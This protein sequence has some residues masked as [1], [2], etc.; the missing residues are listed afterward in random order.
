[1]PPFPEVG[2]HDGGVSM[3]AGTVDTGP[4]LFS[5]TFSSERGDET[6]QGTGAAAPGVGVEEVGDDM[7]PPPAAV[8]AKA[9]G[10]DLVGE[11]PGGVA[12]SAPADVVGERGSVSVPVPVPWLSLPVVGDMLRATMGQEMMPENDPLCLALPCLVFA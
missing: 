12:A 8:V 1:M 3:A 4:W 10:G 6:W 5:P 2:A 9:L 11:E 7:V